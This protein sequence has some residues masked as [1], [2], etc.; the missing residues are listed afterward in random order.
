MSTGIPEYLLVQTL[1]RLRYP[2]TTDEYNN[3]AID[4]EAEPNALVFKGWV[5]Q[6]LRNQPAQD[7][8][9]RQGRFASDQRFLLISNET[10]IDW[11]DK[12]VGDAAGPYVVFSKPELCYS[13]NG[14]HHLEATLQRVDD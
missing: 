2:I 6:D 3:Q 7:A 1:T 12:I 13:M 14:F 10:D 5:Q 8:T 11:Q 9:A 4:Y